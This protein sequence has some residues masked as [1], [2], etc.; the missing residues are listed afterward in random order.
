LLQ[1]NEINDFD[2]VSLDGFFKKMFH[3][4]PFFL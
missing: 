1:L 4:L 2:V 3:F